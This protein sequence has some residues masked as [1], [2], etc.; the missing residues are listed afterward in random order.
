MSNSFLDEERDSSSF[1]GRSPN[2]NGV[3]RAEEGPV[4]NL[5]R[6]TTVVDPLSGSRNPWNVLL[7]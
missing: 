7:P 2:V 5:P 6:H 3:L 4:R 1:R